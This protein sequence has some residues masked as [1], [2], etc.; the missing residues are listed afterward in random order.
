MPLK[1]LLGKKQTGHLVEATA[2]GQL[3]L[4]VETVG[5]G[6][7]S[8]ELQLGLSPYNSPPSAYKISAAGGQD[9]RVLALIGDG[10]FQVSMIL[11]GYLDQHKHQQN[12]QGPNHKSELLTSSAI[13]C[14]V[15]VYKHSFHCVR[16]WAR[17]HLSRMEITHPLLYLKIVFLS[18]KGLNS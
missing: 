16:Q 1:I 5:S 14:C 7:P 17:L 9:K 11:G 15:G 4:D 13:L 8:A 3:P 10:S 18:E 12:M 2:A 6:P